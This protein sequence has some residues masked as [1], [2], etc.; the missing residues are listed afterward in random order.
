MPKL[1][2]LARK[3]KKIVLDNGLEITYYDGLLVGETEGLVGIESQVEQGIKML[4][5]LI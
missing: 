4:S 1:S 5:I 3:E 2:E